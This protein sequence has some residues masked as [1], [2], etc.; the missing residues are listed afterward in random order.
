MAPTST[1]SSHNNGNSASAV[2]GFLLGS[3]TTLLGLYLTSKLVLVRQ[4]DNTKENSKSASASV[5][6]QQQVQQQNDS[7]SSNKKTK[8][9]PPEIREEQLSRHTLYFG[10]DGMEKLKKSSIAVVGVGGVGSHVAHMVRT[11]QYSNKISWS[12]LSALDWIGLTMQFLNKTRYISFVLY[13]ST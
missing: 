4:G 9:I 5:F 2:A 7:S 1:S 6:R 13:F 12:V 8:E 10:Q 11:V 3:A